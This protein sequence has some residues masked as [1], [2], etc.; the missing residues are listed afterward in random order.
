[1]TAKGH[2][3]VT[4]LP[5]KTVLLTACL[6]LMPLRDTRPFLT[7][8]EMC[9]LLNNQQCFVLHVGV[10]WRCYIHVLKQPSFV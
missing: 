9:H 6:P 10:P 1:M 4:H 3:S 2:A 7:P 8:T 5:Q